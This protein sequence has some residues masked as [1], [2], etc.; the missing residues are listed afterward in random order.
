[1]R[2]CAVLLGAVIAGALAPVGAR[3]APP[4]VAVVTDRAGGAWLQRAGRAE[5][6]APLDVLY[7]GDRLRV[8]AGARVE[9]AFTGGAGRVVTLGG[10]GRFA[11]GADAVRSVD[12]AGRV[13]WRDLAAAWRALRI[14][15]GA[16]GR[17]SIA[18]RGLRAT[19][20]PL[21]A[22]VGTQVADPPAALQWDAPY[23][24]KGAPWDYRVRIVDPDGRQVYF[25]QT[26]GNRIALAPPPAWQRGVSYLWTV[27][28]LGSDGRRAVGRATF[29][30]L[31]GDDQA[32]L[33]SA[34][35]ELARHRRNTPDGGPLA[36]DVLLALAYEQAGLPPQARQQWGAVA[37]ARPAWCAPAGAQP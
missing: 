7:P 31:D 33:Q 13:Q 6:L 27:E 10:P 12:G 14:Q 30:L 9:I 35:A 22:P 1:M 24:R 23:G 26:G 3:A 21:R 18:L 15:P 5:S 17:A 20:V 4:A 8:A 19:D 34:C 29:S 28:A 36:E 32:R 37:R 25:A 16:V 11:V 2:R